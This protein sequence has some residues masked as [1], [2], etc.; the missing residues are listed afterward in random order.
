M[1]FTAKGQ[2][3][4]QTKYSLFLM[5]KNLL[6]LIIEKIMYLKVFNIEAQVRADPT[7]RY[8]IHIG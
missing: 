3:K 8:I 2:T 6:Y 7:K 4:D 5:I 1:I